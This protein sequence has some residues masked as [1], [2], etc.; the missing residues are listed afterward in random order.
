MTASYFYHTSQNTEL[1]CEILKNNLGRSNEIL[2]S[3]NEVSNVLLNHVIENE[4]NL[5]E[6]LNAISELQKTILRSLTEQNLLVAKS[7]KETVLN[8]EV[9][10][11]IAVC[12]ASNMA[13]FDFSTLM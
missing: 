12:A 2:R 3:Q 11:E 6:L 9:I 1:T 8:K 4:T 7:I 5:V 13:E 10:N